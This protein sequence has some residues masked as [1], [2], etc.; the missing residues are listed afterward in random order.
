MKQMLDDFKEEISAAAGRGKGATGLIAMAARAAAGKAEA[1][2]GE[3]PEA[4]G[5]PMLGAAGAP[6]LVEAVLGAPML[7][8]AAQGVMVVE[9]ALGAPIMLVA[10]AQ[11]APIVV[12]AAGAPTGGGRS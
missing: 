6:I 1:R 7:V 5:A 11:G 9:A 3:N 4:I 12:E 2:A 8:A 10:A